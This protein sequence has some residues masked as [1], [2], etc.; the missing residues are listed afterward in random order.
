M[1]SVEEQRRAGRALI[2]DEDRSREPEREQGLEV[3]LSPGHELLILPLNFRVFRLISLDLQQ[4][5][6][7]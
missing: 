2:P 6:P 3:D 4:E 1:P 5:M 7:Q